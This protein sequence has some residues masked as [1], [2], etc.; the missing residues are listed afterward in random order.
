MS[1]IT[2]GRCKNVRVGSAGN[3]GSPSCLWGVVL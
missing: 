2:A 1:G 3:S